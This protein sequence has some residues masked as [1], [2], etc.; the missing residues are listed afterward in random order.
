MLGGHNDGSTSY[1]ASAS[2]SVAEPL[3]L[4]EDP[5]IA[6]AVATGS[7]AV[8]TAAIHALLATTNNKL[9]SSSNISGNSSGSSTSNSISSSSSV[10]VTT[11]T[12]NAP[13]NNSSNGSSVTGGSSL[14]SMGGGV[15]VRGLQEVS[16]TDDGEVAGL[17]DRGERRFDLLID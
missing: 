6:T 15:F 12:S 10:G 1:D 7:Y 4:Y 8:A 2:T 16:V 13:S 3:Q 11:S 9:D 5:V 17:V 14:V